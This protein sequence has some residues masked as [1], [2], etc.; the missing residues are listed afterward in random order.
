MGTVRS[1]WAR[2]LASAERCSANAGLCGVASTVSGRLL[3]PRVSEKGAGHTRL[4]ARVV[5]V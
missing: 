3:W 4:A 1:R 5:A 2:S